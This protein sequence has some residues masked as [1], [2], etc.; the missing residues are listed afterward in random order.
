MANRCSAH[1]TGTI[2][3]ER[4]LE[5][6]RQ[7]EPMPRRQTARIRGHPY[8]GQ[9]GAARQRGDG[10]GAEASVGMARV[11]VEM[12]AARGRRPRAGRGCGHGAKAR[13]SEF[14]EGGWQTW[15]TSPHACGHA[16]TRARCVRRC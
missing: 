10:E 7:L 14:L 15:V 12:A 11:A 8:N 13:R 16:A 9:K 2:V 4:R 1:D 6:A 5:P 3:R